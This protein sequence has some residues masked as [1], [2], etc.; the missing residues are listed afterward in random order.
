MSK[1]DI[2]RIEIWCKTRTE[3]VSLMRWLKQKCNKEYHMSM[4]TECSECHEKKNSGN[5]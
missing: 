5:P 1:S 2:T 4:G 3:A